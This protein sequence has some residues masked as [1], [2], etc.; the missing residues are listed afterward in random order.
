LARRD[1]DLGD[2]AV[3][4]NGAT[5]VQGGDASLSLT[6]YTADEQRMT[7][8]SSA[9]FLLASSEKLTP[10]LAITVDGKAA[11][12]VEINALFAA[13]EVPAGQHRVL[14]SRRIGRGWWW[15]TIAGAIAFAIVAAA[16]IIAALR[17]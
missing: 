10:E 1:I 9:P 6:R 17:R 3:V 8:D 2:T 16:E 11:K 13:V 15:A 4:T 14:F 5:R 7:T 12:P